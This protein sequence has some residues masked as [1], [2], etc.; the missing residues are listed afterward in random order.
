[1]SSVSFTA[2][3]KASYSAANSDCVQVAVGGRAVGVRDT[4]QAD[5]GPILEFQAAAWRDFIAAAKADR[6]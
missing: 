6:T 2:W 3:R 4:R 1:M 5:R